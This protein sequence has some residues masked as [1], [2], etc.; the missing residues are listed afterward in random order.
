MPR[1]RLVTVNYGRTD[2]PSRQVLQQAKAR[3]TS[4]FCFT[5]RS[6]EPGLN[7]A[8]H[9]HRH[10]LAAAVQRLAHRQADPALADAVLLDVVAFDPVEAD[11]DA[12]FEHGF[13]VEL[14]ARV[15]GEVVG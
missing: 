7:R 15:V 2:E 5:G 8:I 4:F 12:A 10:R 1:A 3:A 13:V 9:L 6:K 14:A 11:A